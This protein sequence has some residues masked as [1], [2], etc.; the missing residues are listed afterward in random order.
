M[1]TP[2]FSSFFFRRLVAICALVV[3]VGLLLSRPG[4]E[5]AG[6]VPTDS[7]CRCHGAVCADSANRRYVHA[8][9]LENM[10]A[11]CHVRGVGQAA[12]EEKES[13]EAVEWFVRDN[14]EDDEHWFE[15]PSTLAGAP[16][17]LLATAEGGTVLSREIT[18]PPLEQAEPFPARQGGAAISDLRV[19]EVKKGVFLT[20]RIAWKTDTITDA[21]V[22]YGEG[23]LEAS[24]FLDDRWDTEHEITITGLDGHR[25][26]T[27]VAVSR[28]IFGTKTVSPQMVLSTDDFYDE[29]P[30][31]PGLQAQGELEVRARF[32]QEQDRFFA[33]FASSRPVALRLGRNGR[34][35]GSGS[36]GGEAGQIPDDH[37]QLTDAYSLTITVCVSCHPDAKGPLSHPVDVLPKAGM[38]IP[39]EYTIMPD[40]RLS[41]MSCHQ[42]HASDN[43]Y[44]L[45][46]ARRKDLCLG[47][48]RNLG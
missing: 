40:G 12:V 25:R 14:Q 13:T 4:V 32:Y 24:T 39:P 46:T 47:C 36:T 3:G 33:R 19:V 20:A 45:T 41:C 29:T 15:L 6:V 37:P 48:H 17:A 38:H 10:C 26:Y 31:S 7:C 35:G 23:N 42:A 8:P 27:F 21:Q 30:A 11:V 5:A 9:V 2:F 1:R 43:E 28:D 18:L 34:Q 16:L 44:R 22:F